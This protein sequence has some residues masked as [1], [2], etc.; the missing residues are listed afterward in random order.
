MS[1]DAWHSSQANRPPGWGL[2]SADGRS[3]HWGPWPVATC[4]ELVLPTLLPTEPGSFTRAGKEPEPQDGW[5]P[6]CKSGPLAQTP[7][8]WGR[9]QEAGGR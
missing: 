9:M 5:V 1:R 3:G 7:R 2:Q 4:S 8:V 6:G